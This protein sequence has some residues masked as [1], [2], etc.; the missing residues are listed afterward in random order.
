MYGLSPNIDLSFLSHQM[1][2][3]VCI[4]AHDLLLH[5]GADVSIS[6]TSSV[7]CT[8]SSGTSHKYADFRQAAA[9]VAALIDQTVVSVEGNESGTLTLGFD[10]GGVL[11]V[12]DD[13]K[14]Y[15]S[16]TIKHGDRVIV[17]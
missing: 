17:V 11:V 1:L 4:G 12:F 5:F 3:Q 8:D 14:E 13:S 15:E 7:G 16:Y 6:V 10:G 9:H 2:I